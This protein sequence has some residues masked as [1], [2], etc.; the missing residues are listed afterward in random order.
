MG[1]RAPVHV[2]WT[3]GWDSTFRV[4]DLALRQGACVQPHY[5]VDGGRASAAYE[6]R[7]VDAI[8]EAANARGAEPRIRA[9]Q[10]V[11]LEAIP[12]PESTRRTYDTLSRGFG[13][14]P[15]NAYL[16]AYAERSGILSLELGTHRHDNAHALATPDGAA[17]AAGDDELFRCRERFLA[18]FA[19]PL[20]DLTKV[21]ML[22]AA[23]RAGFD[24]L[25]E[26]TWFCHLPTSSGRPCGFCRPCRWTVAEGLPYR[27]SRAGRL[28]ARLDD[29]TQRVPSRKVRLAARAALRRIS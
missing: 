19:F 8:R 3:G 11:S 22:E 6:M 18:R 4:L 2:L 20:L 16:M 23:R 1:D 12:V 7:A 5:V 26:L 24:D 29:I 21:D 25:M 9:P 28:R 14:A 27:V 13:I 15:Q 17:R 10:R